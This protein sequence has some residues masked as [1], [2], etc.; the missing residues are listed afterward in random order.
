VVGVY[1]IVGAAAPNP[2]AINSV[3]SPL[4][5]VELSAVVSLFCV[6]I[7]LLGRFTLVE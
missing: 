3:S 6:A 5:V 4:L 1:C 2:P 7:L